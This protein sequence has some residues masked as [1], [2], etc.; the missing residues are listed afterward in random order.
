MNHKR[1]GRKYLEGNLV[2]LVERVLA[3]E[4]HD[5]GE[6]LLKLK[7]AHDFLT[8]GQEVRIG[9]LIVGL[10]GAEVLRIRVEPMRRS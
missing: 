6:V 2:S 10:E 8:D 5:L 1:E 4:L 9:L 7:N 3:D